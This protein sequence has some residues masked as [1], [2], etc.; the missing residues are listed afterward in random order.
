[1]TR[2]DESGREGGLVSRRT[3]VGAMAVGATFAGSRL[4]M[5]QAERAAPLSTITSPPRDFGPNGAPT[6]YFWDPDIVAVDPMFNQYAQPNSAITRLWTGALWSEGPA[7]NAQGRYLMWSD[8]PNNRQLRWLEDN[9]QVSVFRMPSNYSN[10]NTFDFQGRQISCEHLSRRVVRYE[11]DGSATVIADSYNGK[12][13][14]SPNDVVPHP[15]GSIWFTDP[16]YGGQLYEGAPDAAG[17]PSNPAGKLNPRLGRPAGF[18][19]WKRELPTNVYRADPSGRID[20]VVTEDQVPDP[21][22]LLFSPDYKKLY[23]IST[24]KGPGDT[25]PGGKGDMHVFDVGP[26]NKVSNQKLFTDFM[27]DGVKCGPDGARCDVDGN[28]WCSS[29]AGRAVGYNGVTVWTPAG[30]LI[31]R[32]RLP[33]VVANVCFGGPKRNR[34][35]MAASQSLY[36][37]Y[38]NTQGATPG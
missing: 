16:P 9:G 27:V 17:G 28:L 33:E 19:G 24:G 13:L 11:L 6:T 5:A 32:I 20:V 37:V 30:K 14:N 29:N 7:W 18:A 12:R 22:G 38:V 31:G 36:A 4:A 3:L 1:M 23:V 8:I 21:N 15:D 2:Q 25:G 26:D 10:G 34:L 35:F